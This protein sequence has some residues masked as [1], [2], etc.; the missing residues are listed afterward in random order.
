MADAGDAPV[1]PFDCEQTL[2]QVTT[3][4]GSLGTQTTRLFAVGG[5]HSIA[6][7][8]MKACWLRA[9]SP[10]G[11]LAL[12]HFDSHLDTVDALWGERWSHAS[13]FRRAIEDGIV[14]P[15][16]MLSIGIKGPLNAKSD[17]DFAHDRGVTLIPHHTIDAATPSLLAA[18][19][20]RLAS[21]PAYI[22]FDIDALDPAYAPGTGTPCPGG[23]TTD[24]AFT[25]L[26]SLKGIRLSG[27]DVVEVLPDRDVSGITAFA[28][29]HIMFEILALDAC[30]K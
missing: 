23:L 14:D 28:A 6:Y 26:R 27:A 19:V 8:N 1:S 18:F 20:K 5:D 22:T 13:P 21:R 12:V 4:A 7:A 2:D 25:L 16:A 15:R 17:L 30:L 3:W 11:G 10:A 9:G 29:A 24:H